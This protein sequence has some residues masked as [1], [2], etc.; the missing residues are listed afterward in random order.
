M[1]EMKNQA[2]GGPGV[3][4]AW[5]SAAKSGIGKAINA[6]SEVVFTISKGIVTEVY[7]P[8]EDIACLKDIGL[9]VTDG[10]NFFS[11]ERLHTHNDIK[12]MREGVPAYSIVNTCEQK[13]YVIKKEII[14]DPFRD[15]LLQRIIFKPTDNK[16]PLNLY[17]LVSP[18]INNQGYDNNGR[19]GDYKGINM[20][21]ANKDGLTI[22]VACSESWLKRSVGYKG[23]SD[24][25]EDLHQ[26]KEMQWE[27][28]SA[29]NGNVVLAGQIDLS[30]NK[31][32]ILAVGFGRTET[33]AGNRAWASLLDGFK[34]CK[35][36]YLDEWKQWQQKF[37]NV[38][39]AGNATGK[40]FRSSATVL[41]VSEAKS[42]PGGL[43]ASISIPWGTAEANK[44]LGGYHV[45]WPR[46]LV[47]SC[48]G[49]MALKAYEDAL[50]IANYLMS[51]QEADGKWFQ[52]MWLEG[53]PYWEAVQM[54]QVAL[55]LLL[56]ETCYHHKLID[57]ERMKRYWPIIK[58]AIAFLIMNGPAT[59]QD[60]WE[61][62][63]GLSPY[64]LA[65][66]VAGLLAG[67]HLAEINNEEEIAGYCCETADYWNDNIERWT[68][69]E[70]TK[71]AHEH[72]VDGYY[73]RINPYSQPLSTVKDKYFNVHHHTGDEGKLLLTDEISVDALALVRFGLRAPDDPRILNTIRLIDAILKTE[74]PTGP[75]WHRFIKD[76]YGENAQ[77]DPF[78]Y[79]GT[80]IG[81]CWPL[82]TG[83][84]AH[85][86]LAAGNV[87]Q[88]KA[89]LKTMESFANN[90]LFPEQ[91]WDTK[92]IPEK[93]L[94][95]GKHTQSAM[96][97]TWA[98]AEYLKLS[99]S[100]LD[101]KVFDMPLL[102]QKRYIKNKKKSAHAVWRF[103]WR[104]EEM[105]PG[106]TLRIEVLASATIHWSD[107]NWQT[108][109]DVKTRNIVPGFHIADI[110]PDKNTKTILFTFFWN[111]ANRWENKDYK[112]DIKQ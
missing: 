38:K 67:A 6:G 27:Y 4:P 28:D 49:F 74:T 44:S 84:R 20:L 78:L 90:G 41:R 97:L 91:I 19:I 59:Q 16:T 1:S 94:F 5:T 30:K 88:A 85:Y 80:G 110:V 50:R 23:V 46:D 82:L 2:P 22:A 92:D 11:D 101:K 69:I 105:S 104:I 99:C 39:T 93:D 31:D 68:Y 112:V 95:F 32:F 7:Y 56:I 57:R 98:H 73:V 60:R 106:K 14:T 40:L 77:G 54:D 71:L 103:N 89:L 83:E 26:H 64:T 37:H 29:E 53:D 111:E 107:D 62:Q 87:A 76:G 17:V 102:T 47:E 24:A 43:I 79:H 55:P 35:E 72:N 66:E 65:T 18:H 100:I 36:R 48:G 63:P 3:E 25:W 70:G 81:R 75:C 61:Q 10:K 109:K 86:E 33:E 51:T 12:M 34:L 9:V 8:R 15:T 96:P 21:F 58:K 42:F 13:K 45:V 52:N 108:K